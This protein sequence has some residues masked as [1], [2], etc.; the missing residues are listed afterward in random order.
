MTTCRAPRPS[1]RTR[2]TKS[3]GD[4]AASAASNGNTTAISSPSRSKSASFCGSGVRWKCGSS[5]W[6]I[7]ARVRLEDECARRSAELAPDRRGAAQQ[8][9][10]P[11]VHA[12]E[13]ADGEHRTARFSRHILVVVNDEHWLSAAANTHRS[14]RRS[15][16]IRPA[17]DGT[18]SRPRRRP[19]ACRRRSTR[20]RTWRA[21]SRER[22]RSTFTVVTTVSPIFTGALKFNVCEM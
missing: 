1:M 14:E 13:I 15:C 3:S 20:T 2:S 9:L 7:F 11:A 22:A 21:S 12:V 10:M 17:V 5:G 16:P 19:R 4:S 18:M 8:R 6:K